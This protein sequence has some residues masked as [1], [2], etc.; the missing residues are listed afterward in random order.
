MPLPQVLTWWFFR[1]SVRKQDSFWLW[2]SDEVAHPLHQKATLNLDEMSRNRI[3][4]ILVTHPSHQSVK[5]PRSVVQRCHLSR[6]RARPL[7][8]RSQGLAPSL[9]GAACSQWGFLQIPS[10][11]QFTLNLK[12]NSILLS[13]HFYLLPEKWK[14]STKKFKSIVRPLGVYSSVSAHFSGTVC[15]E[16]SVP[17]LSSTVATVAMCLLSTWC[18]QCNWGSGFLIFVH[19]M[20]LNMHMG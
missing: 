14:I 2:P 19:L 5:L 13:K 12:N 8:P 3:L 7:L 9:V 20:N 4:I 18:G 6:G 1:I 17:M 10:P 11:C 15:S 16:G